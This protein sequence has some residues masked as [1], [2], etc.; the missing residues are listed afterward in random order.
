MLLLCTGGACLPRYRWRLLTN[1]WYRR[2]PPSMISAAASALSG[3]LPSQHPQHS[4]L[5]ASPCRPSVPSVPSVPSPCSPCSPCCPCCPRARLVRA[6]RSRCAHDTLCSSRAP[7]RRAARSRDTSHRA[8]SPLTSE[9]SP[10]KQHA[11][12]EGLPVFP[13][14]LQVTSPCAPASG[15]RNERDRAVLVHAYG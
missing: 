9:K 15:A 7:R 5:A 10:H 14:H 8:R 4:I 12:A 3:H 11:H 6:G 13:H 2:R 1:V